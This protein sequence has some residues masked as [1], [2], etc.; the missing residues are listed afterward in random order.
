[1]T[2]QSAPTIDSLLER[3]NYFL[4]EEQFKAADLYF[5]R[6]LDTE[7]HNHA[8]YWGLLLSDYQCRTE[9]ELYTVSALPFDG[10]QNYRHALEYADNAT[11]AHYRAVLRATLLAC[12][13][14]VLMYYEA[15]NAFLLEQWREH[16]RNAEEKIPSLES[17]HKV[18]GKG[19]KCIPL[20]DTKALASL[21]AL[22]RLYDDIV[23]TTETEAI[24]SSLRA[25]VARLYTDAMSLQ[26]ANMTRQQPVDITKLDNWANPTSVNLPSIDLEN[27][28]IGL[29]G[30][31]DTVA[32]RYLTLAAALEQSAPK[33]AVACE[34]LFHCYEQAEAH[35][36]S[37]EQ[38]Q[39][40]TNAK[41]AFSDRFIASADVNEQIILFF[42]EKYPH[43]GDYHRRYVAF[44]TVDYT[45]TLLSF[46]SD[47]AVVNFLAKNRDDYTDND[48]NKLANK[49][50][51]HISEVKND[52]AAHLADVTPH[53][54]QAL[55]LLSDAENFRQ[56]WDAYCERLRKQNEKNLAV[57][58]ERY[59][60]I[61]QKRAA[62]NKAGSSTALSKGILATVGAYLAICL[63]IPLLLCGLYTLK[64]AADLI[65]YPLIPAFLVALAACVTVHFIKRM[66][67]K[68]LKRYRP[69]KYALPKVCTI[70]LK[71][72][73]TVSLVFTLACVALFGYSF[74]TYPDNAGVIPIATAEEL[75]Y[76]KHAPHADFKLAADIDL[77][78]AEFP[79]ALLFTGDLDG[80]GHTIKNFSV[81]RYIIKSH[82][83]T[84]SNLKLTAIT[85]TG[86]EGSLLWRNIGTLRNV[87]VNS[88]AFT[89]EKGLYY[90]LCNTNKG[91][92][93]SCVI[94]NISGKCGSLYGIADINSGDILACSVKNTKLEVAYTF[95][96]IAGR[97]KGLLG[98]CSVSANV[99]GSSVYGIAA[100]LAGNSPVVQQCSSSGSY[101]GR[102]ETIG[103]VGSILDAALV[104]NS[105]STANLT[106]KP[107]DS[108]NTLAVG[109]VGSI[110]DIDKEGCATIKNC[111]FSGKISAQSGD[112]YQRY[113][114]IGAAIGNTYPFSDRNEYTL[115]YYI[116]FVGCFSTAT[117]QLKVEQSYQ[118]EY[119]LPIKT[120]NSYFTSKLDISD[121]VKTHNKTNIA[122]KKT[123]LKKK[124]LIETLGFDSTV[125]NVQDG[126]FPTLKPYVI[127][128][129]ENLHED[130]SASEEV[131]K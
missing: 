32:A 107:I 44:I 94:D 115:D 19:D 34:R 4:Q 47:K 95:A 92:I 109:M 127:P 3:G 39:T 103:L 40:A 106:V 108:A 45:K 48:V 105:Y 60:Q 17:V 122:T 80:G 38:R 30:N 58:N 11:A 77:Q 28:R 86:D 18:F 68:R 114:Y 42:I 22:D 16:Y 123:I 89:D 27:V 2:G 41:A 56:E 117:Y 82:H 116:D 111:Y 20:T 25:T 91:R 23:T 70:L 76:I 97:N 74:F 9:E 10:N 99:S 125:W 69:K 88:L 112:T 120:E 1:M 72:A 63:S 87:S 8:A 55:A 36:I 84:I 6:V 13:A 12:H 71:S 14:R 57:L 104:E 110:R 73:P 35:A 83:G 52:Y 54:E 119:Y 124:F 29:D 79:K 33:T 21:L 24:I 66:V 131:S 61:Q 7:P 37:D 128:P 78:N 102:R 5:N 51:E 49:Q 53:A 85:Q 96:G 90:G 75:E 113:G 43:N 101:T 129:E 130:S 15:D 121:R 64:N 65:R 50:C 126:K 93:E 67:V 100:I 59:E 62:D 98:G 81:N 46:P 118:S 26:L 31:G